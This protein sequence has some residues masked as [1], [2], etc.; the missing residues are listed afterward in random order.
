ML[1]RVEEVDGLE[2]LG[3]DLP[4]CVL[5]DAPVFLAESADEDGQI[6][7]LAELHD[8]LKVLLL[9]V[10]DLVVVLAHVGVFDGLHDVEFVQHLLL[11]TF[12]H[13][14]LEDLLLYLGLLVQL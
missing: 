3:K 10:D 9:L 8:D 6:P 4:D 5:L 14:A 2:H 12:V 11:L 13:L 1:L 7:L